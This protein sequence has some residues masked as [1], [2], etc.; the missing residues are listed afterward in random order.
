LLQKISQILDYDFSVKET[1]TQ[2][3]LVVA[4]IKISVSKFNELA[5]DS[6]FEIIMHK[7]I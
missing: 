1:D 2:N 5:A 3:R 4:V 6:S 7:Q